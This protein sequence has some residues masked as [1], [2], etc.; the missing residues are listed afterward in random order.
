MKRFIFILFMVLFCAYAR[1]DIFTANQNNQDQVT[2]STSADKTNYSY[3]AKGL[4]Y[5]LPTN[6][7]AINISSKTNFSFGCSGYDFNTSFLKQFNAQ[8]L[9]NDVVS[10]GQQVMAAAPLLLL[11]YASPTL[12]DLIKHFQALVN[13]RLS[14]DIMRCQDIET[15]VDGQFDKMR[16]ASEKECL[17]QNQAMGLSAAMTYC[18]SQS[19][20]FSFLKDINGNPLSAGGKINVVADTLKRLGVTTTEANNTLAVTGDT[21]ITKS[22]YQEIGKLTPYET[23]VQ[24]SKDTY[25]TNFEALLNQY[26]TNGSVSAT[27][28]A[29]FSRPGVPINQNFLSNLLLL[30]NTQRV[31]VVSKLAS[32]W[33]YL[34]TDETYRKVI[35]YYN[36]GVS[37]PNNS[38]SA[39]DILRDKKGKVEYELNKAKNYYQELTDLKEVIGSVN[40]DADVSRAKLMDVMDST[41]TLG[42]DDNNQANRKG[43]L[44]NF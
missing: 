28:L 24:Q 38:S 13:G 9:E 7:T 33:A 39:K 25:M 19:D 11:D 44:N 26:N 35:D 27:D 43:F 20:P 2:S 5:N 37:D 10:Q 1:A 41:Q 4:D 42:Q 40:S 17:D 12:A 34:D 6:T 8:A 16:K 32:Y 21:Q 18:K 3:Q 15:A 29:P 14:L 23:M 36:A 22:G 31:L 30:D